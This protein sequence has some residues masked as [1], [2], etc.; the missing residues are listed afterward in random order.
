MQC[1]GYQLRRSPWSL[2]LYYLRSTRS[3]SSAQQVNDQNHQANNQKQVDQTA[4][5]MQAEPQKPHD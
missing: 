1:G 2:D 4:A 3:S 5:D